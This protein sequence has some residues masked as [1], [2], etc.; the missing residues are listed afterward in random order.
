MKIGNAALLL[1]IVLVFSLLDGIAA[2]SGI[3]YFQDACA[4]TIS[5]GNACNA[6]N[7]AAVCASRFKGGVGGCEPAGCRCVYTCGRSSRPVVGAEKR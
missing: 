2:R 3:D 1:A 4:V 7:C 6:S 5:P